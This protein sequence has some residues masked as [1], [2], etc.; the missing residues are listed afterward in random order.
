MAA[1]NA[2]SG[3]DGRVTVNG[4]IVYLEKWSVKTSATSYPKND[5]ESEFRKWG[6]ALKGADINFTGYWDRVNPPHSSPPNFQSGEDLTNLFLFVSKTDD[7]KFRFPI[8]NC[9]DVEVSSE[10]DGRVDLAVSG[11]ST[12]QFFYPGE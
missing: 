2:Y 11:T 3:T 12:G 6:G 9:G 10:V 5:Y 4:T 8:F 1:G 7:R